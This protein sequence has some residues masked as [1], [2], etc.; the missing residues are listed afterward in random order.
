MLLFFCPWTQVPCI[1]Y[2][3]QFP[4]DAIHTQ[5]SSSLYHLF[6]EQIW[7]PG[8][9]DPW[10]LKTPRRASEF[11]H[12]QASSCFQIWSQIPGKERPV[13]R[14]IRIRVDHT[15]VHYCYM[16]NSNFSVY[17]FSGKKNDKVYLIPNI[18]LSLTSPLTEQMCYNPFMS[19]WEIMDVL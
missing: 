17:F 10:M 19:D 18:D 14:N 4:R 6:P 2:F 12:K 8:Q 1:L 13:S 3:N 5:V 9:Y 11:L 7:S 16:M 15:Q